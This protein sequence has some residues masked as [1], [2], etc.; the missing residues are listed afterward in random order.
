MGASLCICLGRTAALSTDRENTK[1]EEKCALLSLE[2]SDPASSPSQQTAITTEQDDNH[3]NSDALSEVSAVV[4]AVK[5]KDKESCL[6]N[7]CLDP[8]SSKSEQAAVII[9][10]ESGHAEKSATI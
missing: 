6:S 3:A 9:E 10:Q 1:D 7:K 2:C 8:S 4:S 5:T